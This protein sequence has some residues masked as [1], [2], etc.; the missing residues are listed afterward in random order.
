[1][2]SNGSRYWLNSVIPSSRIASTV[3]VASVGGIIVATG[4]VAYQNQVNRFN[5]QDNCQANGQRS[6][7][8]Q[9]LAG[10]QF[11]RA[12]QHDDE[13]EQHHDRAGIDRDLRHGNERRAQQQ[14]E[15]RHRGEVDHQEQGRI[16]RVPAE[17]HP[18]RCRNSNQGRTKKEDQINSH[19]STLNPADPASQ[20][21]SGYK[22]PAPPSAAWSSPPREP[23]PARCPWCR[24]HRDGR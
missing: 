7:V 18:D 6:L 19:Q 11:L 23:L 10:S 14:V 5:H 4:R 15:D 22:H 8:G 21:L 17:Q 13:Q 3:L 1:M 12:Q 9:H 2:T 20:G 16:D 24:W